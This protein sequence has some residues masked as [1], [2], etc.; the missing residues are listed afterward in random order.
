MVSVGARRGATP[1]R[2][3]SIFFTP[4]RRFARRRRSSAAAVTVRCG[5]F[6][7][8]FGMSRE[9]DD[10]DRHYFQFPHKMRALRRFT[11]TPA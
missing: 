3:D 11:R 8:S 5:L 10:I 9:I 6:D 4:S 7:A 1:V 2:A